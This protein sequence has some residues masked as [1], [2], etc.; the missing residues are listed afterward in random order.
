MKLNIVPASTGLQWMQAGI[1]TFSLQPLALIMLLFL[2]MVLAPLLAIIPAIGPVLVQGLGP[3]VTLTMMLA[4]QETLQGQRPALAHMINVWR[5]GHRPLQ[6]LLVLGAMHAI[7]FLLCLGFSALFD[8]GQFARF[9][10]LGDKLAEA[11]FTTTDLQQSMLAF[12]VLYLP[13]TLLF[14]HAPAL[15]YWHGVSPIKSIFFSLVACCRN[16]GA[17]ALYGIAWF[18][19]FAAASIIITLMVTLVAALFG[20]ANPIG[21]SIAAG[22]LTIT[23]LAIAAMLFTSTLFTFRDCFSPPDQP[24]PEASDPVA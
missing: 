17:F 22:L 19:V 12:L 1:R 14:W 4:T 11:A 8:G 16:L 10:L 7:G 15:V 24:L 21:G 13:L 3:M 6:P 18:G 2:Y 20:G 5:S 9:Y 23:S